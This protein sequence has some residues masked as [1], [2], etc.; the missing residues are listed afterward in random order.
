MPPTK[1]KQNIESHN[2][3][4]WD[5]IAESSDQWFR[6]VNRVELEAAASG[7][8]SIKLTPTRSLPD[9]W[10][11]PLAGKQVLCL[12]AAGGRQ[13]P[14]LA[15]AGAEV[16]ILDISWSQL[17]RDRQIADAHSLDIRLEQGDM[18][19]LGRFGE[20]QFDLVVNPCSICYLA[21]LGSLWSEIARVTRSGGYLLTGLVNPVNYLFDAC[22]RD[23]NQLDVR[24]SLPLSRYR[25]EF[26]GIGPTK[27]TRSSVRIRTHAGGPVGRII[28][29]WFSLD[30]IL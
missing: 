8:L 19:D 14:L 4:A 6:A 11:Q 21:D 23:R 17:Q 25:F 24:H 7:T 9:T 26:G 12:A 5:Q 2:Q 30:R 20:G 10:L 18:R 15:A 22:A 29:K 27:R 1:P 13:A 3:L 16:T 28:T